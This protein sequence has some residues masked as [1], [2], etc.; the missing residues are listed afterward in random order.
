[1][2]VVGKAEWCEDYG[3]MMFEGWVGLGLV[4][5]REG[6]CMLYKDD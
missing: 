5:L 1:M 2:E 4:E 3:R 6:L